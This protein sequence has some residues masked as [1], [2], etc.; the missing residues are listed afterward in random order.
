MDKKL[1][2]LTLFLMIS[3]SIY[4]MFGLFR[5]QDRSA[6]RLI[7]QNFEKL[8]IAHKN[9]L[10]S[11]NLYHQAAFTM[12]VPHDEEKT[13]LNKL[14]F[15]TSY[16]KRLRQILLDLDPINIRAVPGTLERRLLY[17]NGSPILREDG[18]EI[19]V[20]YRDYEQEL[21]ERRAGAH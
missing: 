10:R 5:D 20:D 9:Y 4:P 19:W 13:Q 17:P 15:Y 8:K 2:I 11:R 7:E 14:E 1:Q 18:S 3:A 6:Q 12:T 21:A 16:I